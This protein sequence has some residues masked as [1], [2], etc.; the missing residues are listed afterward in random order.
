MAKISSGDEIRHY[1]THGEVRVNRHG[2]GKLATKV[3]N[4]NDSFPVANVIIMGQ[5]KCVLFDA[6]GALS[7]AYRCLAE[8]LEEN[9]VLETIYLSHPHPVHYFGVEAYKKHFPDARVCAVP[10]DAIIIP[11]QWKEKF[12]SQRA[13]MGADLELQRTN[14]ASPEIPFP[15]EPLENNLIL[16]EGERIEIIPRLMGDY[17]YNTAAYIPSI[18][19]ICCSDALFNEA[20]PFTCEL[21][22]EDRAEWHD[23]CDRLEAMQCDVVVPG[24]FKNGMPLDNTAFA[25]NRKYIELTEQELKRCKTEAEFYYAMDRHFPDAVLQK[26]NE[27]NAKVFFAGMEWDWR[28]EETWA[29]GEKE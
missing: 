20:H 23:V 11:K 7:N 3:F 25:W 6:Q 4:S 9:L 22:E 18:S 8:I 16:L 26:S 5:E 21:T 1:S 14:F 12:E 2:K 29:E 13:V 19:T 28:E 27:M 10:E 24:H 17:R 15:I